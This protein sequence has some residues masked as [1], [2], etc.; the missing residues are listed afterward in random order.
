MGNDKQQTIRE[1]LENFDKG[2]YNNF[3]VLVQIEAGWYDWFCKDESLCSKTEILAEKLKQIVNSHLINQDKQYVFF[4][5][6]CPMCGS[7]YDDFRI[8]D[9]ETEDVIWTVIPSNGHTVKKNKAELWGKLNNFESPIVEGTW[10][11]IKN[12]FVGGQK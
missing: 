1:F 6:N 9:I 5:N 12:Y 10:Q 11:E 8:C 2:K 7:L 4:K 3:N